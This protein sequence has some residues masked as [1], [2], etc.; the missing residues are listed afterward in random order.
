MSCW[1]LHLSPLSAPADLANQVTQQLTCTHQAPEAQLAHDWLVEI[2][3]RMI[4]NVL[5]MSRADLCSL[6]LTTYFECQERH[7]HAAPEVERGY[8]QHQFMNYCASLRDGH[9]SDSIALNA[10]YSKALQNAKT[11]AP[12]TPPAVTAEVDEFGLLLSN[13]SC[14]PPTHMDGVPLRF[15]QRGLNSVVIAA[16]CLLHAQSLEVS[17]SS[18]AQACAQC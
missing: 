6:F 17:P 10:L 4:L 8:V 5:P 14:A 12:A 1:A 7:P 11:N 13:L 15:S 3:R 18:P 9:T 2:L 16:Y